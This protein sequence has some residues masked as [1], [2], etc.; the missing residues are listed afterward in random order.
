MPILF[1]L[2]WIASS[3]IGVSVEEQFTVFGAAGAV[4]F[5]LFSGL[6][7]ARFTGPSAQ[8]A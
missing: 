3:A 5:M 7:V 1:G 2:G 4:V 6:L 8:A